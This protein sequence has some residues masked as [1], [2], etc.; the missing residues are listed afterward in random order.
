MTRRICFPAVVRE[1]RVWRIRETSSVK[2]AVGGDLPVQVGRCGQWT[3]KPAF[4]RA[5]V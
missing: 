2:V 1:C 4:F 3:S 5:V